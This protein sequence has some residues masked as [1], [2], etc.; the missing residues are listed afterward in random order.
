MFLF[1]FFFLFSQCEDII[2]KPTGSLSLLIEAGGLASRAAEI[3]GTLA[4]TEGRRR[5]QTK[6][7]LK[8]RTLLADTLCLCLVDF[9]FYDE[10]HS[11]LRWLE[12]A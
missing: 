12:M 2:K 8:A 6:S 5:G 4:S 1:L 10:G 9:L 11:G 3:V 7:C